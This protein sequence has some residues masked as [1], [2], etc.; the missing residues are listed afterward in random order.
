MPT[1]QAPR[2][3]LHVAARPFT[4]AKRRCAST[5]RG[6]GTGT[7]KT[8]SDDSNRNHAFPS[9]LISRRYRTIWASEHHAEV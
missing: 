9:E 8:P 3:L 7:R 4:P 2:Y 6:L 5:M 1:A